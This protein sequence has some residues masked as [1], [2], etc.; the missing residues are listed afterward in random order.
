L[1]NG[2]ALKTSNSNSALKKMKSQGQ[3]VDNAFQIVYRVAKHV[4]KA[5]YAFLISI[6]SQ[7]AY[8]YQCPSALGFSSLRR[9]ALGASNCK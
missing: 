4:R 2:A 5:R 1:D 9:W 3:R 8:G 6:S 7:E